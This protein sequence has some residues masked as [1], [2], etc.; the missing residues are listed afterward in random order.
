M[1]A[2]TFVGKLRAAVDKAGFRTSQWGHDFV[3][4]GTALRVGFLFHCPCGRTI[5]EFI[6]LSGFKFM[7][8][9]ARDVVADV[10]GRRLALELRKHVEDE[11][12]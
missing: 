5:P 12:A 1:K 2:E 8:A 7:E 6:Q 9:R 4:Y 11:A 3:S 10:W